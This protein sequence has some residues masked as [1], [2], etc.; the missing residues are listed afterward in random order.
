MGQ[1]HLAFLTSQAAH[2][3]SE[4]Y[5]IRYPDIQYPSLVPVDT[6]APAF[7]GQV[8][9]FSSDGS[10]KA[11]FLGAYANDIPFVETQRA[12]HDVRIENA[13]IGYRYSEF[14]LGHAMM[15]GI[16]L[17]SDDAMIARRVAEE[18]IDEVVLKGQSDMGWGRSDRFGAPD[19]IGRSERGWRAS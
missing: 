6:S 1:A 18:M 8:T 17:S 11:R 5:A 3:E 13:A 14:E 15:L 2:I 9:Y 7:A 16:N 12:K 4:V 10:G 19:K